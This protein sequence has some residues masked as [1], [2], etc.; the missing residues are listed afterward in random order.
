MYFNMG[1]LNYEQEESL[2]V[3]DWGDPR[4]LAAAF[5]VAMQRFTRKDR[6]LG[7]FFQVDTIFLK[8]PYPRPVSPRRSTPC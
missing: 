6:N 4:V 2:T 3:A 5:R 8:R 1:S 7:D